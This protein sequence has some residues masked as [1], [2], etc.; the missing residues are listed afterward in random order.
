MLACHGFIIGAKRL[1]NLLKGSDEVFDSWHRLSRKNKIFLVK[2]VLAI[3]LFYSTITYL[4]ASIMY[5]DMNNSRIRHA[6]KLREAGV[7]LAKA[8]MANSEGEAKWWAKDYAVQLSETGDFVN[9][10][11]GTYIDD[12]ET[13]SVKE[14]Y[15]TTHFYIWFTWQGD[16][17]LDPGGKMFL[18]D[19]TIYKKDLLEEYHGT[20]GM[21]YQRYRVSARIIKF[22]DT[23][24][25]P[26]EDHMLNI[27]V[28]DSLRDGGKIHYVADTI[29]ISPR[30]QIPGFKITK[31]ANVVQAHSYNSSYGDPRITDGSGK[32][33]SQY[34]AAMRISRTDFGF[35]TEIFLSLF[36]AILLALFSFFIRPS[37]IGPRLA[38]PTGAY[39][40]A[41]ANSYVANGVLPPSAGEFGLVDHIAGIG[42]FTIALTICLSLT[43]Y[44]FYVRKDEKDLAVAI[45]RAMFIAVGISCIFANIIIPFCARG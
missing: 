11:V 39:F 30:V 41:V 32:I 15:W 5:K 27:Y 23:T 43:S 3:F 42:L 25:V 34:L 4:S 7:D 1:Y 22:F 33:F 40:G 37:D 9:V 45:D 14:S 26:I 28:E 29:N 24:R 18:V 20:D 10:K 17:T 35:Y 36:A 44:H 21:N 8:A 38:L 12:I 16:K 2:F 6:G 31:S 19:G 13:L